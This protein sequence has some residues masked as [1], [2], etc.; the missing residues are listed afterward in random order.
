MT[1]EFVCLNNKVIPAEKASVSVFDR[2]LNYGDG[3]FETIKASNGKPL[4]LKE[5]LK[6]LTEGAKALRMSH[7]SI[8]PFIESAP[9]AIT[10]LLRR[11]R[12]DK[13]DAYVKLLITRGA[14]RGG[15]LP[16]AD[17][18]PT[19]LIVTKKLDMAS[20]A[21]LRE[22]GASA[23]TIEGPSPAIPGVKSL[24]YLPG[25]LARVSADRKG[26]FE[27]LFSTGGLI[28]EGSSTNVFSIKDG[29]VTTPPASGF[30]S[31]GALP[32]VIRGQV[33]KLG[34]KARVRFMEAPLTPDGLET[35]DEAFL[36]NS[37]I[38]VI[39]LV[40][41]NR[42]KV[43]NGRVGPITR[44]FQELLASREAEKHGDPAP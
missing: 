14:D 15:H 4:F 37:I 11:N 36:T 7:G 30:S 19:T 29:I 16:A 33:L 23:I 22:K 20:L 9:A 27:A 10:S 43:G 25:V 40:K 35:A 21:A 28:M 1:K 18:P 6:R 2:G 5:H 24:N 38:G 42:A 31:T 8:S 17:K 12:L 3:L 13:G 44:L 34:R 41:V 32:G 39:P 26:A